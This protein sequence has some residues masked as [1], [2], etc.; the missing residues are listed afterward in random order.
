[1]TDIRKQEGPRLHR[2]LVIVFS[3]TLC[4]L[5]YWFLGFVMD[6]I[7]TL[8]GPE[9]LEV[10]RR[11][12]DPVVMQ[13]AARLDQQLW[14]NNEQ[15]SDV[16]EK[17]A[18]LMEGTRTSQETLKQLLEMQ[19]VGLQ[20]GVTPTEGEQ[21]AFT[22]SQRLF[23]SNQR[24]FQAYTE[25]LA[26]LREQEKV[27]QAKRNEAARKL[28]KNQENARR[29]H[30]KLIRYH[31]W[32]QAA[33]KLLVLIPLLLIVAYFFQTKRASNFAPIFHAGGIAVL[34]RI[35]LVIHEHFPE[36]YFKYI[37]IL[38]AIGVVVRLLVYLLQMIASPK[39]PWLLKKYRE[40]YE[41][42]FCPIC[43]YP[44]R[45]G[46]LKYLLWTWE[47]RKRFSPPAATGA[48]REDPYA[49]P[50]CGAMLYETCTACHAVRHSLLPY[51]EKCGVAKEIA[52]PATS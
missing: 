16:R 29:E 6:D 44:I 13:E 21:K 46:P 12:L 37:V 25:E 14:Q 30:A 24:Q 41:R 40:A 33:L 7:R 50:A 15:A 52:A 4:V 8:P 2:A 34:A 43:S 17:Q 47:A 51:C 28:A 35:I 38:A 3:C 19:R 42:F 31:D 11:Y 48:D 32:L 49:C 20:K 1:M 22:E 45:R 36:R 27:L 26:R 23:L 10:E 5:L 18:V 39:K 9:Y